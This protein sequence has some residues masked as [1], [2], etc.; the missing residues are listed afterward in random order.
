MPEDK[1][2]YI[3]TVGVELEGG[4]NGNPDFRIHHD[5]SVSCQGDNR[6]EA[7]TD[8]KDSLSGVF[9]QM[10]TKYPHYVDASCGMHVHIKLPPLYYGYLTSK[11]FYEFFKV[12]MADLG[13][14]L[15]AHTNKKDYERFISRFNGGNDY[16][17]DNFIPF[18]QIPL[19]DKCSERY[20]MLNFC[21]S[22]HGTME[23]RLFPMCHEPVNAKLIV[24]SYTDCIEEFLENHK[25]QEVYRFKV[26]V[27]EDIIGPKKEDLCV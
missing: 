9:E 21:Y 6:G 12:K 19:R 5:G 10:K 23:C 27:E 3:E 7:H 11:E 18:K 24:K 16:C 20:A 14:K 2:K 4:W 22:L 26:S 25:E 13:K 17:K 8:P 1:F 15:E